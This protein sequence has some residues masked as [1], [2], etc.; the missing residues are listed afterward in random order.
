MN[1]LSTSRDGPALVRVN[2]HSGDELDYVRLVELDRETAEMLRVFAE[3][4][5]CAAALQDT[6]AELKL[7]VLPE[8]EELLS[9]LSQTSRECLC[10]AYAIRF[11]KPACIDATFRQHVK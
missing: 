2:I 4:N 6:F 7:E 8:V 3:H 11:G 5:E 10:A 9:A 1:C